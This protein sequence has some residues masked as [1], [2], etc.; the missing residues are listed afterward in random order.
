MTLEIPYLGWSQQSLFR[1]E[2]PNKMVALGQRSYLWRVRNWRCRKKKV[3]INSI[4]TFPSIEIPSGEVSSENR[5][6]ASTIQK[7]QRRE[8]MRKNCRIPLSLN[9]LWGERE[10]FRDT[11]RNCWHWQLWASDK[12]LSHWPRGEAVKCARSTSLWPRVAGLDL[13]C[14]HGTAWHT[15]CCGRRPTYKVEEDGHRC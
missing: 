12:E 13:G 10:V 5:E 7:T 8:S 9:I 2:L 3:K 1:V 14:G 6:S 11:T 4:G 15:P